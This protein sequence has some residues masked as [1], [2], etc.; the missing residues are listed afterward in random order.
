[1]VLE[2]WKFFFFKKLIG[3]F[4]LLGFRRIAWIRTLSNDIQGM[5]KYISDL[6][7]EKLKPRGINSIVLIND[8]QGNKIYGNTEDK[9]IVPYLLLDRVWEKYKT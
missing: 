9:S 8:V 1:V 5:R 7:Y 2:E 6:L 4:S 3:F